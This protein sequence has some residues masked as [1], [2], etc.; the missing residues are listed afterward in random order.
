MSHRELARVDEHERKVCSAE[1]SPSSQMEGGWTHKERSARKKRPGRGRRILSHNNEEEK[2]ALKEL[3]PRLCGLRRPGREVHLKKEA[4]EGGK[5]AKK[6][7]IRRSKTPRLRV[8]YARPLAP[9]RKHHAQNINFYLVKNAR[10]RGKKDWKKGRRHA[11]GRRARVQ[12]HP[13]R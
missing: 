5:P 7:K 12:K 3:R 11:I 8:T 4:R 9:W 1:G 6:G 10:V 13:Q 2:D